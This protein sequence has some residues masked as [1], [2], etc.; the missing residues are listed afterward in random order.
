VG[1]GAETP[2]EEVTV[3]REEERLKLGKGAAFVKG[4][5]KRL[6]QEN[7]TWEADFQ[8]LPKPITQNQTHYLGMVVAPDGSF[9]A[10]SHIEGRP[11]VNDMATLLANAMRRPLAGKAHRPRRLHVRGHPQW[12]EL[13][14][15]L[16][17]LGIKV[18]VHRELFKV[19][20]AYQGYLRQ[21][22]EAH[23]KGMVKPTAD[24]QSV[25]EVF[26]AIAQWVRG[27]GHIEIGDQEM[28]GFVVRALG[29]GGLAFEDDKADT[30]AEAMASLE[31]GL[32]AFF[33]QEGIKIE[34]GE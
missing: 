2:P 26:P 11:T 17:E 18:A 33:E 28:F 16:E 22:R 9:L 19:Q 13:F 31:K 29:Y 34:E 24:Q 4:R 27:Y 5:L 3:A 15:H 6:R 8:A 30:L 20:Q 10:D 23:R 12:R 7:E 14:P 1:E 25:E 21:R 32:T